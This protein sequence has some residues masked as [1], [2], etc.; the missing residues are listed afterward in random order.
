M[1]TPSQPVGQTISHYRILSR[2]GGG[3]MGVVYEAE[4]LKLGRHVAL[5]FLP[6]ELAHDAQAL[7]RFQREAKAASSLNHPNI[8][9]IYEIDES[10]DGGVQGESAGCAGR[11]GVQSARRIGGI[12][13]YG[14]EV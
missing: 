4:D 5:K 6:D 14:A 9:T 12:A 7:S 13:G 1:S 3:G 11:G 8:C 10:D 2:I